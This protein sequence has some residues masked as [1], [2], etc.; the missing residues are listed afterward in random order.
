MTLYHCLSS[1]A[2][3][4]FFD[5]ETPHEETQQPLAQ[6]GCGHPLWLGVQFIYQPAELVERL[7]WIHVHDC[8]IKEV[9]KIVLHLAG[10]F[11]HLLQLLWLCR[12][13]GTLKN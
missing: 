1:S 5:P 4:T 12:E 8:C 2:L 6:P 3:C 9:A 11:N 10:L 7:V 13:N